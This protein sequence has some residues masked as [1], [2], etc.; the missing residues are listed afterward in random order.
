[1]NPGL[2][3]A[4]GLTLI[5]WALHTFLG[6]PQVAGPL[7]RSELAPIEKYTSYYCWHLVTIVLLSMGLG[8]AWAATTPTALDLALGL[9]LVS[10]AFT[11][12][13][14]GLVAYSRRSSLELPQWVLFLGITT[15]A[16]VGLWIGA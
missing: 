15:A 14:L 16:A 5:T 3:T 6:G 10:A 2:A 8:F 7:L 13:G 9:T 11:A 4:A 12:W 1:M